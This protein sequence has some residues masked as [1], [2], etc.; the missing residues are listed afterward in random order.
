MYPS[1]IFHQIIQSVLA[2]SATVVAALITQIIYRRQSKEQKQAEAQ[3]GKLAEMVKHEAE[4][5][6][7]AAVE[8]LIQRLPEGQQS[9]DKLFEALQKLAIEVPRNTPES[10]EELSAVENLIASYHEQ[11]LSQAL[12]QFWFSVLAA[13]VG[14]GWLLYAGSNIDA[15][16]IL[17]VFKI[18]PGIVMDVVAFLFFKQASETRQRATDLY[19]RLRSD[20]QGS[21]AMNLVNSIDDIKIRSAV[22]AQI[23]LHKAGLSPTPIDVMRF[24]TGEPPATP[25]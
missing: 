12:I 3:A 17:T 9:I 14:F 19:D 7:T 11:A 21:E 15:Q 24:M 10:S 13:T 25:R 4:I 18:L 23:A 1:E 5:R 2:V 22:Q 8:Q 16:Q 6:R 20:K